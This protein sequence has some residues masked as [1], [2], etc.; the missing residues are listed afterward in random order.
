MYRNL[1]YAVLP[2][3]QEN[4]HIF[5]QVPQEDENEEELKLFLDEATTHYPY[6]MVV[7]LQ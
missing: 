3:K 4:H 6:K 2:I 5:K 7:L 1:P